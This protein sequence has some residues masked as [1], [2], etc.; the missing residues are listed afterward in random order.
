MRIH[1]FRLIFNEYDA[2]LSPTYV[3]HIIKGVCGGIWSNKRPR[4]LRD[5]VLQ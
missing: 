1:N 3:G 5:S 2:I 4:Q